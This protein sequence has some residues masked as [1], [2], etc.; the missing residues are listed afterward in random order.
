MDA[1]AA[2]PPSSRASQKYAV[3]IGNFCL[4]R[5]AAIRY[6]EDLFWG[7]QKRLGTVSPP[8]ADSG[9]QL[10]FPA[11]VPRTRSRTFSEF[12]LPSLIKNH[13]FL[14]MSPVIDEK[15]FAFKGEHSSNSS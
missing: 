8:E 1:S 9:A 2:A 10:I 15:M 12:G 5:A 11:P 13:T 7:E 4:P 6:P 3:L 14:I